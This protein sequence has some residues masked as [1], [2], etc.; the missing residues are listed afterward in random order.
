MVSLSFVNNKAYSKMATPTP[1]PVRSYSHNAVVPVGMAT[2]MP[3]VLSES[4]AK[5]NPS[6]FWLGGGHTDAKLNVQFDEFV[7]K[8][9]PFIFDIS[10]GV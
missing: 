8:C 6:N 4:I 3:I 1:D 5:L 7:S 10:K 2:S 9:N